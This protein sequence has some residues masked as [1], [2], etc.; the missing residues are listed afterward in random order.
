MVKTKEQIQQELDVTK[1]RV[2]E[3]ERE[4]DLARVSLVSEQEHSKNSHTVIDIDEL[5]ILK[6]KLLESELTLKKVQE[7]AHIGS[8]EWDVVNSTLKFSEE[9]YQIYGI[10]PDDFDGNMATLNEKIIHPDDQQFVAELTQRTIAENKPRQIEFR[11]VRKDGAIR[12]VWGDGTVTYDENGVMVRM[13]GIV[14]DITERKQAED[15]LRESESRYRMIVETTQEGI[16]TIDADN[17][18]SFVNPVM[19]DMLG[20]QV[21]EMLGKS[22]FDFMDDEGRKTAT[23]NVKR[24]QAGIAEQHHFKLLH[25]S[26]MAVWAELNTSPLIDSEGNY[27]GALAMITDITERRVA[28]QKL[29]NTQKLLLR[30]ESLAQVGSWDWDL[31]TNEVQWSPEMYRIYRFDPDEYP[32][33][34]FD[35]AMT[36]NHSDDLP[37][38]KKFIQ[39]LLETGQ[40]S[41]IEY[42]IVLPNKEV[43]HLWSESTILRDDLGEN[44]HMVGFVQDI[45]ER[46]RAEDALREGNKR[47]KVLFDQSSFGVAKINSQTGEFVEI[48]QRYCDILGYST[49]EMLNMDFQTITLADD[50]NADLDLMEKLKTE[51][52][53]SFQLEKRYI[54]KDGFIIW[55]NLSVM[56]LWSHGGNPDFHLAIVEDISDRKKTEIMLQHQQEELQHLINNIADAIIVIDQIGTVQTFSKS[57]ERMFG[58]TPDEVLGQSV[59]NLMLPEQASHH[60]SYLHSYLTTGV[61]KVIGMPREVKGRRKN[62]DTFPLR[63]SVAELPKDEDGARRFI[64]ACHDMTFE[65]KHEEQLRRTQKM[66][67]LGKLTGGIAHDYNNMLGVILGYSKL[68]QEALSEDEKLSQ[69]TWEI[70]HASER[71]RNLSRKLLGF[72]R[73]TQPEASEVNINEL[74]SSE[75]DMLQKTLTPRI[76][77]QLDLSPNIWPIFVNSGELE[78]AILNLSIN[79]MHAMESGGNLY[80]STR[81][82]TVKSLTSEKT[83]LADGDYVVISI[84]DTGCGISPSDLSLIFDPFFTTKGEGGIGL[85]LSMVYG[86]VQRSGGEITVNSTP[87]Y[88]SE[89][90]L[91]FPRLIHSSLSPSETDKHNNVPLQGTECMLIVDDEPAMVNLSEEILTGNGYRVLTALNADDALELFSSNKVDMVVSD[92]VMPGKDGYQLAADI[93]AIRPDANILL[94]SGYTDDLENQY[95]DATTSET[96]LAKPYT[97]NEF[98]NNIRE[99][100]GAGHGPFEKRKRSILVLEDDENMQK[101]YEIN[102]ARLGYEVT[103]ID[104]GET[105]VSTYSQSLEGAN[106]IDVVILDLGIPCSIGGEEVASRILKINPNAKLIVASGN[107]A[108]PLMLNWEKYGFKGMLD[109]NFDRAEMKRTLELVIEGD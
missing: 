71:G 79:A 89:F 58:F 99:I 27:I 47:F 67:A 83:N 50:L 72:S 10:S 94:V 20:Y 81:N 6:N 24:R 84:N 92:V 40:T 18:T 34:N 51:E 1:A 7:I 98:L 76:K 23:D 96:L 53:P 101:L 28:E 77:L 13:L 87:G 69:Y 102:L 56:P 66:D 74:L 63:L 14:Q 5:A 55:V 97:P 30:T 9:L 45:T 105:A 60:D 12:H 43:C 104:D 19:A 109:K 48:N 80:I 33:V 106:P 62:G 29:N 38:I 15:E 16:W 37:K 100:L 52:I 31:T 90:V 35:L 41:A 95:S 8:W 75:Q 107:V 17:N 21:N 49:A 86:F 3:L 39:N 44:R 73:N 68:L 54:N 32:E 57:A 70:Q 85:G 59:N 78:D 65:K 46:K 22:M 25:K 103:C 26:G 2:V 108:S 93:R 36:R 42:R 82:Q 11:I 64:G 91:S 61:A 88:G 4:L